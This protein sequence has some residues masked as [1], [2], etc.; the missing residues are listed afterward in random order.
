[1]HRKQ[2]FCSVALMPPFRLQTHLTM[3]RPDTC[4]LD[5]YSFDWDS[6]WVVT[7]ETCTIGNIW[8]RVLDGIVESPWR[9]SIPGSKYSQLFSRVADVPYRVWNLSGTC[10]DE[11]LVLD[12]ACFCAGIMR[13]ILGEVVVGGKML[14]FE[15]YYSHVGLSLSYSTY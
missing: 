11:D 12:A 4:T 14:G 13:V 8:R 1:M 10:S 2:S 15:R 3:W 6:V 5:K 9:Q 7:A